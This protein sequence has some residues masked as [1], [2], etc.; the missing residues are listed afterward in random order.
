MSHDIIVI[1]AAISSLAPGLQHHLNDDRL[2]SRLLGKLDRL[3]SLQICRM[4]VY[5]VCI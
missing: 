4:F 5:Y 2:I 3:A 1:T